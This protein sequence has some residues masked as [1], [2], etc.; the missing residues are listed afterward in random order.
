MCLPCWPFADIYL[1]EAPKKDPGVLAWD[2][3]ARS[4]VR[5]TGVKNVSAEIFL[6]SSSRFI[7]HSRQIQIGWILTYRY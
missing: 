2:P 7:S 5:V 3:T 4:V 6:P 1:E